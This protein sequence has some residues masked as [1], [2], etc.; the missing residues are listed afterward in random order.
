[1]GSLDHEKPHSSPFSPSPTSHHKYRHRGLAAIGEAALA[2][3]TAAA[4]AAAAA[5][6][7]LPLPLP[8]ADPLGGPHGPSPDHGHGHGK[9]GEGAAAGGMWAG[10]AAEAAADPLLLHTDSALQVI[11]LQPPLS[12]ASPWPWSPLTV[13]MSGG[14]GF[15]AFLSPTT[16]SLCSPVGQIRLQ[17]AAPRGVPQDGGFLSLSL[18]EAPPPGKG[19]GA[20]RA[21]QAAAVAAGMNSVDVVVVW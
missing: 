3:A 13:V 9:E 8:A 5:G 2:A 10:W 16:P 15:E 20:R 17:S 18:P 21:T 6:L 19:K 14:F 11:S 4:A 7:E 1:M 12:P